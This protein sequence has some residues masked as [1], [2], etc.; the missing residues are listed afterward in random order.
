MSRVYLDTNI[1]VYAFEGN[2]SF[3]PQ[4]KA[5]LQRVQSKDHLLFG[6]LITLSELLVLPIRE[7]NS[8]YVASL[9]HFFRSAGITLV[10]YTH[11][12]ADIYAELR[13]IQRIKPLDAYHLA[14]AAVAGID[15]FVTNDI[16]LT[17][18]SVAGIGSIEGLDT[19]L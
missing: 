10:R 14:S 15:T 3:G 8:S 4:A 9:K 6:S 12:S 1:F 16:K 19:Q 7:G 17:K 2:P 13:A 5:I 11:E 18:L